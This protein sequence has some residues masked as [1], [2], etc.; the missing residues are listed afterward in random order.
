MPAY[1]VKNKIYYPSAAN[2]NLNTPLFNIVRP[3]NQKNLTSNINIK[4]T[5]AYL[6]NSY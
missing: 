3:R 4:F 2:L 5:T 1:S 6:L